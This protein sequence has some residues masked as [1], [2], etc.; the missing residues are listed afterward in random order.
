MH[1]V[2]PIW[3]DVLEIGLLTGDLDGLS[4]DGHLLVSVWDQDRYVDSLTYTF[5]WSEFLCS[6]K[7]F[8][9]LV[10]ISFK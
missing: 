9:T 8:D 6:I 2:N 10:V 3:G 4:T 1:N 7:F 5:D